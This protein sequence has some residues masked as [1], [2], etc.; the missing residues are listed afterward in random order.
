MSYKEQDRQEDD[1]LND[2]LSDEVYSFKTDPNIKTSIQAWLLAFS[3]IMVNC[4]CAVMWMT[5]SSVPAV[6]SEW[7]KISLTELNW[8][9]NAS[10]ICNTIFSLPTAWFYERFGIKTSVVVC[11]VF[12]SLGCW[13]RCF[14]IIAHD[15]LKYPIFMLGQF[16]ASMSGPLVYNLYLFGLYQKTVDLQIQFYLILVSGLSTVFTIPTFFLP[17]KPKIPPSV[18]STLNRTP[19]W[20]GVKEISRNFQF[21]SVAIV[22]ASTIGMVFSVSVLIIEAITP[23]GYTDQEAGLCA[24]V[25]VISGFIGGVIPNSFGTVLIACIL[26]GLFSYAL[27]P[28]Y[29]ELASEI[30]YPISESIGSCIIWSLC[31]LAMVIFSVIIDSLKAGPD[32]SPPNNMNLSMRVVVGI[33]TLG[34]VPVLWMK[35]SLK[36]SNID[37]VEKRLPPC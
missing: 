13:I 9:S 8:L 30:T 1:Q 19:F 2:T 12:N 27:F 28:V 14:A 29:L 32:A 35:G 31:T 4:F 18:T 22:A 10:A 37:N 36:R 6:M 5:A 7:M 11:A 15:D 16:V 25:V 20:Q 24:S 26:N 17:A 33:I 23:F 3:C 21:W 34:N